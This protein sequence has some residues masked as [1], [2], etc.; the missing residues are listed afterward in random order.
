MAFE[1]PQLR[2]YAPDTVE[3]Q[4]CEW[5]SREL[6]RPAGERGS[7]RDLEPLSRAWFEEIEHK[8]Y[9]RAGEWLP[10]LLEFSRH[11][12]ETLLMIGPGLGTDAIQYLRHGTR[13]TIAV[14]QLDPLEAIRRNF[15]QR[16]LEPSLTFAANLSELPYANGQFDLAYW[17]MLH[18]SL[19]RDD[20]LAQELTRVIKPGGK[21]FVLAPAHFDIDY[22]QRWLLPFRR[23][24]VELTNPL[25]GP[26]RTGRDLKRL[27]AGFER[28]LVQKRQL[29]RSELPPLWRVFPPSLL[30]RVAGRILALRATKPIRSASIRSLTSA[31]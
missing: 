14:S 10:R 26:K 1:S 20:V 27:F 28:I 4:A 12:D 2:L 31:A 8:R 5:A 19:V 7:G 21:I 6:L 24:F 15:V 18:D 29:R 23:L 30:E 13:V 9:S 3:S 22:W 11:R 25:I 17:N 16:G